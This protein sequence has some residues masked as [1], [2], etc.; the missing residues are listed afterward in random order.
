MEEKV[1]IFKKYK[2]LY[3]WIAAVALIAM[4]IVMAVSSDF[5]NSMVL[6]IT[7]GLLVLF[8][9]IRFVPLI[10]TTRNR[11]AIVANGIE[12]FVD[13]VVGIL[14]IYFTAKDGISNDTLNKIYPFLVGGVLYIRGAIYFAETSFFGTKPEALKFFV[15]LAVISAGTVVIARYDNFNP[16]SIGWLIAVAFGLCGI[17]AVV[18]GITNY[19]NYRKLYVP[20]KVKKEKAQEANDEVKDEIEAPAKDSDKPIIEEPKDDRGQDY[21]N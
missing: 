1:S 11:W 5:R 18:D 20:K 21:V 10:K 14:L 13:L 6:Y 15:H 12:M 17:F 4:C 9:I 3:L 8:V 16:N 2:W 7:G 19:N